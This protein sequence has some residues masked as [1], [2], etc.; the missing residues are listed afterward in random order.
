MDGPGNHQHLSL[1]PARLRF[2]LLSFFNTSHARCAAVLPTTKVTLDITAHLALAGAV[3]AVVGIFHGGTLRPSQLIERLDTMPNTNTRIIVF[4]DQLT[5]ATDAP[6]LVSKN[7]SL[8]YLSGLE[9][10]LQQEYGFSLR[11]LKG[12]GFVEPDVVRDARSLL[13]LLHGHIQACEHLGAHWLAATLQPQRSPTTRTREAG[14][15]LRLFQSATIH[16]WLTW[17]GAGLA[18]LVEPY[19]QMESLH[20]SYSFQ[21][22][23]T[24]VEHA[25]P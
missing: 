4:T 21:S 6:L 18:D 16:M 5:S 2:E 15:R 11:V 12:D 7:G 22:K 9:L 13:R 8:S 10:A 14:I 3:D 24:H 19:L 23:Q 20:R 25:S 17:P 1:D